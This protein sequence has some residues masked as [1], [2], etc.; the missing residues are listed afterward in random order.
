MSSV[1]EQIFINRAVKNGVHYDCSVG[2]FDGSRLVGV[3]LVGLDDWQGRPAAFDAGTGI[4]PDYRGQ[5]IAGKMFDFATPKLRDRGVQKF[6]LEVLQVNKPAIKA[7]RAAGFS[8]NRELDCFDLNLDEFT[9][10]AEAGVA[11]EINPVDITTVLSLRGHLDWTPS[12][13]TSYAAI[14][15]ID[16]LAPWPTI[17]Y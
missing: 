9:C 6:L 5:G 10:G 1:S 8:I 17:R 16:A 11:F 14:E 15:R 4:I 7:Y 13:E 12:W 3:T 2:V